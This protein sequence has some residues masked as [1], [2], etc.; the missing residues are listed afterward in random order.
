MA[1]II[2]YVRMSLPEIEALDREKTIFLMAVSPI[3]VHGPHLPLGT[4]VFVAEE[5]RGAMQPRCR[6]NSLITP[7]W[8]CPLSTWARMPCR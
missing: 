1:E 2:S 5:L 4:D 7:L 8:R 6:K 3:E